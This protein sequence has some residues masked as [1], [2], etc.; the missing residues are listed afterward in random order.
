MGGDFSDYTSFSVNKRQ[1]GD[2]VCAV[3][4]YDRGCC[5]GVLGV[6]ADKAAADKAVVAEGKKRKNAGWSICAISLVVDGDDEDDGEESDEK[7]A[8]NLTAASVESKSQ[9]TGEKRERPPAV[10]G[11]APP[12][13]RRKTDNADPAGDLIKE[14]RN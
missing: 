5:G 2:T 9:L 12:A 6:K 11:D 7:E 14:A 4:K 10:A 3:C 13:K 1:T 8:G